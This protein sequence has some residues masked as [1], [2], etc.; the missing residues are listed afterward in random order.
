MPKFQKGVSGN[1]NGKPRG[2]RNKTTLA[3][4]ALL[5]GEAE[6]LTR[7]ALE[8]AI[9]GD[10]AALRLCMDRLAPPR[11]D[12]PVMFALPRIEQAS[13]AVKAAAAIVEAVAVGDLTPG[14]AAEL[15]KLLD[16]YARVLEATDFEARLG[17]LEG[18][19]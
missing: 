7:K 4:E 17:K 14:E 16:H 11:R 12:R 5:E 1:P 19:A 3:V 9:S 8:L 13:D 10:M 18:R 2:A 6:N 15:S